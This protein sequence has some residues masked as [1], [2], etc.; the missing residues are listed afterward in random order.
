M[1]LTSVNYQC[2]EVAYIADSQSGF[3]RLSSNKTGF[4]LE[5]GEALSDHSLDLF[6]CDPLVQETVPVGSD[7][8]MLDAAIQRMKAKLANHKSS[9]CGHPLPGWYGLWGYP[10]GKLTEGVT[11]K[12]AADSLPMLCMGFYPVVV[13]T[14]HLKRTTTIVFLRESKT[15]ALQWKAQLE[16]NCEAENDSSPEIVISTFEP[17]WGLPDYQQRFQR[18]KDYILAGDCYQVNLAQKFTAQTEASPWSV[19]QRLRKQMSAPMA[20]Y[21]SADQ[22]ALISLSPERFISCADQHVVT[23]PIKGTRPR[24]VTSEQDQ[25]LKMALQTSEK[26]QAE[27]LMIVDLLRNDLGKLCLWGSVHVQQLFAIESFSNVHHLVSTITGELPQHVHPL[28]LMAAVFPGGS[29]TGA[30]K[31]R[32]MEII[33]ELEVESR[34][35]Y[36]GSLMYCDIS[37]RLDSSILIRSLMAFDGQLECWAG[38]GIVADS[39]CEQEYQECWDKVSALFDALS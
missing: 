11:L 39:T 26:D 34:K 33:D 3:A 28:D 36:C 38:G 14:N 30:P 18:V 19:Y 35:F 29:I 7:K 24:G 1:T 23:K 13:V 21:Y 6:G 9:Y 17:H 16:S 10:I 37:G 15:Q 22:W 31:H 20:G 2:F 27:N 32:A 8:P 12:P 25:T 4:V 5:S